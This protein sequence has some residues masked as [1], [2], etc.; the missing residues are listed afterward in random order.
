MDFDNNHSES[1]QRLQVFLSHAG[2]AS[3]RAAEKI[4]EQGRVSVNGKKINGQGSRVFPGDTVLLDGMPVET[5]TRLHYLALNKPAG[6]I[7]A[8]HDPQGRPLA[9]ELLP[10][11]ISERLYNIGRL[12][13]LSCGLVL[14]TNDG[15]FAAQMGHPRSAPEKEYLVDASGPIP[16]SVCGAFLQGITIDGINYQA[17]E[18]ELTGRT[19]IRIVLIEGKNREIRRVFSHFHLHPVR[20]CRTRIGPVLLGDT[21]D[22]GYRPLTGHELEV[23][24]HGYRN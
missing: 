22:G 20:L 19:S 8:S 17:R 7:C 3:R 1:G 16:D 23:L 6:Y 15:I 2:V 9:L 4:I 12:D 5:E 13:F 10:R 21:P 11:T 14:F 18:A 24:K